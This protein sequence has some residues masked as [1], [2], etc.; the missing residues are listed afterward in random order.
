[1]TE[2]K[3]QCRPDPVGPDTEMNFM[4]TLSL[5]LHYF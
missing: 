3:A 5:Q 4:E 1:M 2:G